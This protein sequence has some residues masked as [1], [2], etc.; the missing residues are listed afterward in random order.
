[1]DGQVNVSQSSDLEVDEG[2]EPIH[3]QIYFSGKTIYHLNEPVLKN[4][5]L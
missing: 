1:M 3:D 2:F 5:Q 4:V